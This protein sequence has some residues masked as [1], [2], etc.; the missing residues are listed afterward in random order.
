ML[1][2]EIRNDDG[3]DKQDC[4]INAA[5]RLMPTIKKMHPRLKFIRVGD[6]LYAKTPFIQETLAQGDHFIFTVKPGDHK[7]LFKHLK[8]RDYERVDEIDKQGRKFIYEWCDD[9]P[10]TEGHDALSTPC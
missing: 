5:K 1:P 10:L 7:T 9:V 8:D 6:S 3:D 2:E 4:E